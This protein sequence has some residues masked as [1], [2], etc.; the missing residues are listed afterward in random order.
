[1]ADWT[2]DQIATDLWLDGALLN[3]AGAL[4]SWPDQSGNGHSIAQGVTSAQP[5]VVL[6]ALNGLPVVR[7]DGTS[8][9]FSGGD[10]I[11]LGTGG[12]TIATVVTMAASGDQTIV[13]KSKYGAAAGRWGLFRASGALSS[14]YV[15]DI[16]GG[17]T[18]A[19]SYTSS[20]AAVVVA[21]INRGAS[22]SNQLW[23]NGALVAAVTPTVESVV[24]NTSFRLLIGAYNNSTD[25]GQLMYLNGDVAELAIIL[26][27]VDTE[28][29]QKI[30]GRLAWKWGLQG[31]LAAS[32]PYLAAAPSTTEYFVVRAAIDQYWGDAQGVMASLEHL[33]GIKTG[34][35]LAQYWSDAPVVRGALYQSWGNA[36]ILRGSLVQRWGD[37]VPLRALLAQPWHL[38]D[39]VRTTIEQP[40]AILGAQAQALLAQSWD[41]RDIELLRASLVQPWA[42][43]A[44][45]AVLRYAVEV[46]AD[47]L[48]VRVSLVNIEADR[49]ED[50]LTC[51]IH[52]ETED[53]YLRCYDGAPLQVTVT[54]GAEILVC[55]LV[56]TSPRIDEQH[57]ETS[58][59]VE[60]MSPAV[61]LGEPYAAT[62][63]GEL[64]GLA[65]A[66]AQ[67]LAGDIPLAWETVD[68]AIPEATWI[69]SDETPLSLIKQL[70]AAVGA[71]VQSL[72]DGSL[73][74]L[75]E[76]PLSVP[77][78]KTAS[79]D[80]SLTEILDCFTAGSTPDHR[81]GY[82]TY[83]I[84]DQLTTSASLTLDETALTSRLKEVRGYQTPWDGAFVLTHTGGDW[85]TIEP[86]GI[87]ERYETETVEIVGGSGRVQYP[88]YSRDAI[89]WGQVNLGSVSFAE[90]GTLSASVAG[91]S[92]LTITY[93]TRCKL[94]LVRDANNEQLQLVVPE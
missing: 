71:V 10:V 42:I 36:G 15:P 77:A 3:T 31:S 17:S 92:L 32:H 76:Y 75:P 85:V 59:V 30:E 57:G 47:G 72:P 21:V 66:I 83:T 26:S 81:L 60:A 48:P 93:T 50:V 58:Y 5:T 80:I 37:T 46:L 4:A 2:L 86:M 89:A 39:S 19:A 28:T 1:M 84:G 65:S 9:F 8:D 23:I 53:E 94:W 67:D 40:W 68:W 62:V 45:S 34:A 69:A 55:Q 61:L 7:F 27:G 20:A 11:D 41:I 49:D 16:G 64:S 14:F 78:W 13:A 51:E 52:P 35:D 79:A 91:Q 82:N 29:R 6:N 73:L 18:A 56:V 63:N 33:W 74:V 43:A 22:P 70:A 90:D 12:V 24:L 54:S 88:I 87:E 44:D 38:Y 25:T